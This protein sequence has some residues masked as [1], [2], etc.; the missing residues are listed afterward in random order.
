MTDVHLKVEV[1]DHCDQTVLFFVQSQDIFLKVET[2][3]ELVAPLLNVQNIL[4][5]V[6][7]VVAVQHA[8]DPLV[9]DFLLVLRQ[10]ALK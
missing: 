6:E 1:T 8:F 7:Q 3:L 5:L 9:E 10:T 4:G 2:K